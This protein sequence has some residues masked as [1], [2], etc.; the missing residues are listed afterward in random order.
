[1]SS[2]SPRP[3]CGQNSGRACL[4]PSLTA[5][6]CTV[7][8]DVERGLFTSPPKGERSAPEAP[9]EGAPALTARFAGD[10]HSARQDRRSGPQERAV[11]QGQARQSGRRAGPTKDHQL[12]PRPDLRVE[13]AAERGTLTGNGD[14]QFA[15]GSYSPPST[16]PPPHTSIRLPVHTPVWYQRLR[17]APIEETQR[18]GPRLNEHGG[19]GATDGPGSTRR[20]LTVASERPRQRCE[21]A[22]VGGLRT[23]FAPASSRLC[24]ER[25][26]GHVAGSGR[27]PGSSS[28][29]APANRRSQ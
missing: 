11:A 21:S 22:Y 10:H 17:G 25:V 8:G 13:V 6:A 23:H 20:W 15:Q 28:Q 14:Q 27:P 18:T 12:G 24:A 26:G 9:G 16:S 3:E 5:R 4:C 7:L 1:M 29:T 2:E 19:Y